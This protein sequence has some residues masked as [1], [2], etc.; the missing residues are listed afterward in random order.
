VTLNEVLTQLRCT[1]EDSFLAPFNKSV[2]GVD[3]CDPGP[4]RTCV[5]AEIDRIEDS[6]RETATGIEG[7]LS[8]SARPTDLPGIR[9][10]VDEAQ[11][12]VQLTE[13]VINF[14]I[15]IA[16]IMPSLTESLLECSDACKRGD[17]SLEEIS[18]RV[19]TAAMIVSRGTKRFCPPGERGVEFASS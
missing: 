9:S 19:A 2:S 6:F 13:D 3:P 18:A 4:G 12:V 11:S 7:L 15:E 1:G 17:T 5:G 14:L 8:H 10:E 16:D